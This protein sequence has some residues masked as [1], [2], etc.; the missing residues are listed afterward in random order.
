MNIEHSE[1]QRREREAAR[2]AAPASPV[3]S[4]LFGRIAI[5]GVGMMGGSLGLALKARGIAQTV[6]GIDTNTAGLK[7]AWEMGAIDEGTTDLQAGVADAV[8]IILAAPVSAIPVLLESLPLYARPDALIT[9]IGGAKQII[10]EAGEGLCGPRFVGGHPMAGSPQGGISA[11][12][13]NL[14]E[15]AAWAVVRSR[16]PD[17]EEDTFVRQAIA[18]ARALGARPVLL[19]S[20]AHDR[21][22]ALVSHLP[23]ILSFAFADMVAG[24]PDP[25]LANRMA[26]SSYADMMRVSTSDRT[27]WR[28]IFTSNRAEVLNAITLYEI[29]LAQLK[30]T[31]TETDGEPVLNSDYAD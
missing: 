2:E 9:D 12:L 24:S 1:P 22:V 11:A 13:P 20:A 21:A 10:C 31:L 17:G 18:L 23:H 7:R 27:F 3:Q 19:D 5:V 14:F 6:V 8:V 28:D 25:A 30:A 15:G 26:G 4:P 29:Q 16:M